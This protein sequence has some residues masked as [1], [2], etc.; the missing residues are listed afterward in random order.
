MYS[1]EIKVGYS[2]TDTDLKMTIPA[3]LDCF[4]DAA[5]FESEVGKINMEYLRNHHLAWLLGS[6]QI[7]IL[8]RPYINEQIK[9]TTFPYDFKGFLG[10]RN[11]TLTTTEGEMLVK[12]SSIW[13]LIDTQ[14]LHPAKPDEE[15]LNGYEIAERLEMDYAPRK[16]ALSGESK[17]MEAF[18]VCRY[19]IDSNRH[20]NN[21]EY[22][23]M[24]MEFLPD[25]EKFNEQVQELRAEY[26]KAAHAGDM[27][28]P[29]VYY[30]EKKLRVQLNDREGGTYAVVEFTL[31][32]GQNE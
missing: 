6:W 5:T 10:Y 24:A 9:V 28:V 4:Q 11:Y 17:E 13:T 29:V 12:A 3:I 30:G 31:G 14:K 20:V 27:I 26:K 2:S 7:V 32:G 16:I 8:R 18:K 23:R 22:I 15:I 19:Q 21:V 1:Y 25:T